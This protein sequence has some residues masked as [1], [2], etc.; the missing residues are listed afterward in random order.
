MEKKSRP[1]ITQSGR[2]R[3]NLSAVGAVNFLVELLRGN[4]TE[5]RMS[6]VTVVTYGRARIYL[7]R[8]FGRVFTLS[9]SIAKQYFG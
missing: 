5:R 9:N 8:A 1:G 6:M 4:S 3:I 7:I 2:G